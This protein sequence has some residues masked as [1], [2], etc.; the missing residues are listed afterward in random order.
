MGNLS[1]RHFNRSHQAPCP[2][3]FPRQICLQDCQNSPVPHGHLLS[4]EVRMPS[5]DAGNSSSSPRHGGRYATPLTIPPQ[6]PAERRLDQGPNRGSRE[7]TNASN[8]NGGARPAELVRE[9]AGTSSA[10]SVLQRLLR[11]L[12]CVPQ[13]GSQ[14]RRVLGRGSH[15]LLHG[16]PQGHQRRQDRERCCARDRDR[17]LEAAERLDFGGCYYCDP[18]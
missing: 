18:C 2:Q 14:G 13:A 15:S 7:R 8:D 9:A 6:V 12:H 11:T 1:L 3:D 5:N 10:R 4:E 16:V 17:L